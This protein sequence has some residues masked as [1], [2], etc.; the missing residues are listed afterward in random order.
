MA[1]MITQPTTN[2]VTGLEALS[3]KV[4]TDSKYVKMAFSRG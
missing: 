2:G 1:E 3:N 4:G